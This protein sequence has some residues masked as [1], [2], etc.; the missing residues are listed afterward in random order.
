MKKTLLFTGIMAQVGT[1]ATVAFIL[2]YLTSVD[3]IKVLCISEL[4]SVIVSLPA[5]L[6]WE[7]FDE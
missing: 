4:L 6:R 1:F 3:A 2:W 5:L 7:E